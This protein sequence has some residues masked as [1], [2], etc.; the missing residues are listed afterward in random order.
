MA[1]LEAERP[2]KTREMTVNI[3]ARRQQIELI[4]HAAEALGK[5]RSSF[6]I[7]MAIHAAEQVLLDKRIFN[8]DEDTFDRF[9]KRLDEPVAY[10]EKLRALL[11]KPAPWEK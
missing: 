2:T 4:D 6:M 9:M 10:N 5:N 11:R 7:E 3:R 8:V 1:V